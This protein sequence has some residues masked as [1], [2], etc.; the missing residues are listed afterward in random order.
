[1]RSPL[2]RPRR[3]HSTRSGAS[4]GRSDAHRTDP[5]VLDGWPR[6]ANEITTQWEYGHT[7][8]FNW[9]TCWL[10]VFL[11]PWL[12]KIDEQANSW[13][14]NW[15]HIHS[16]HLTSFDYAC[17]LIRSDATEASYATLYCPFV[18]NWKIRDEGTGKPHS[19]SAIHSPYLHVDGEDNTRPDG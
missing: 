11:S 7:S 1:M 18:F 5:W 15:N 14:P 3:V 6:C 2:D 13:Q 17:S 19:C 8:A 9:I 16:V 4:T 12:L 10:S